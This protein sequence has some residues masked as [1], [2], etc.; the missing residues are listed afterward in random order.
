MSFFQYIFLRQLLKISFIISELKKIS[1]FLMNGST[2]KLGVKL[3]FD[4]IK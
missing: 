2:G 1:S 4:F 3:E